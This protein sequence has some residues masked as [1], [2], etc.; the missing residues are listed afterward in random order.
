MIMAEKWQKH[1]WLFFALNICAVLPLYFGGI[2]HLACESTQGVQVLP[3]LIFL[4]KSL[5]CFCLC[6]KISLLTSLI[7][8]NIFYI[9]QII[10]CDSILG[11]DIWV[12]IEEK[13]DNKRFIF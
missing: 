2:D 4:T 10:H 12:S 7:T 6:V 3:I 11:K 13:K 1:F 8:F 5:I 9:I